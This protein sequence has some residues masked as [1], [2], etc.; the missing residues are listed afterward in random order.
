MHIDKKQDLT[1]RELRTPNHRRRTIRRAAT[2][3]LGLT[4]LLG[5]AMPTDQVLLGADVPPLDSY[6]AE[7]ENRLNVLDDGLAR[8][9]EIYE[10]DVKPVEDVLRFYS[11]DDTLVRRIAVALVRESGVVNVDPRVLTSVL[12]VE[13]PWLNPSATPRNAA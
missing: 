10:R 7:L 12:L 4:A 13:N 5:A 6:F 2:V 1:H 9:N 8:V 3:V 11:S